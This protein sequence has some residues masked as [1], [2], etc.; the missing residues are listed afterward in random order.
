MSGKCATGYVTRLV[1]ALSGFGDFSLKISWEDEI[2]TKISMRLN[3][4]IIKIED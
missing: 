1:N 3:Q 4:E 2:S